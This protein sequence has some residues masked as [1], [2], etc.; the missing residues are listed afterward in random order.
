MIDV[1]VYG[2]LKDPSVVRMV[3]GQG[4]KTEATLEGRRATTLEG[5]KKEG[6]NVVEDKGSE[7]EGFLMN[8][9]NQQLEKLDDYEGWPELYIRIPLTTKDGQ[10]LVYMLNQNR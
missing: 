8:V 2:T 1:F 6:L 4:K 10:A 5:W 3:L 9:I 7:V